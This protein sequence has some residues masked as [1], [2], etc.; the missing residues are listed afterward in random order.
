MIFFILIPSLYSGLG[1]YLL[2]IY[3]CNLEIIFPKIN[4]FSIILIILSF[5]NN[6]KSL[7]LEYN[8]GIG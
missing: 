6:L 5:Y 3:L 4:N 2:P 1:N 8:I 7:I